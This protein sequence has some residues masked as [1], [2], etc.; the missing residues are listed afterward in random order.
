MTVFLLSSERS[1]GGIAFNCQPGVGVLDLQTL[2]CREYSLDVPTNVGLYCHGA[3]MAEDGTRENTALA[4]PAEVQAEYKEKA[5]N[6]MEIIAEGDKLVQKINGIEFARLEDRDN[7][8]SRAKGLIA[9]QDHGDPVWYRNI[10]IKR[11]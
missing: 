8:L 1:T 10:A 2:E 5:W 3:V 9:L 7:E 11:L 4:D 6:T